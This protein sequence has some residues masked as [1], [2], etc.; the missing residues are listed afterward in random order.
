[1]PN[2]LRTVWD[3]PRPADPPRRVWRDWVLVAVLVPA[4]IVEGLTRTGIPLRPLSVALVAGLVPTLL[5]RRTRPLA[6]VL[7]AFGI[8]GLASLVTDRNVP[9]MNVGVYVLI[10]AYALFRWGSGR[11]MV[12]GG[13]FLVL[14]LAIW[15]LVDDVPP[16]DLLGGYAVL[17]VAST[18]GIAL[19]YQVKL[20][21]RERL[22][23]DLHDTVAHHVSAMAIRAQAG[24]ATA[25]THPQAATDA[26]R[27]IEAE[28]VRALAEMRSMVRVLRTG[29][30]AQLTPNPQ[31]ADLPGLADPARPGPP[32]QVEIVGD[33]DGISPSVGT[34]VY[35]LAQEAVTNARRH[36]RH[37]TRILVRVTTD[38]RTVRL[39]VNDDGEPVPAP[40]AAAPGFGITGMVERATLLG[41]TC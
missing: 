6:M 9:D 31:V 37:A 13:A 36:A 12:L 26:L 7:L 19:R 41:G 35:R 8:T 25:D 5:W 34:A 11:E 10:L 29:Q 20:L 18:L 40:P 4:A 23:R 21:E 22:A 17:S 15:P 1:V 32:V 39:C 24:L 16:G 27:V 38:A 2:P 28:A 14:R 33:L 3:E 30:P